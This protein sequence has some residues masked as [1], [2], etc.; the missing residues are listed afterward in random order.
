MRDMPNSGVA[1]LITSGSRMVYNK[2]DF[3]Q[4]VKRFSVDPHPSAPTNVFDLLFCSNLNQTKQIKSD[5][6][7]FF[8]NSP[9]RRR[10]VNRSFLSKECS[11]V[12][13]RFPSARLEGV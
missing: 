9:P 3:D 4:K 10:C 1:T 12:I 7:L 11:A 8:R 5:D 6:D 2:E 13:Q